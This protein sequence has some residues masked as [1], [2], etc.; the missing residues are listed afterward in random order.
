MAIYPVNHNVSE[1]LFLLRKMNN[2]YVL[3]CYYVSTLSTR[4]ESQIKIRVT[5][6]NKLVLKYGHSVFCYVRA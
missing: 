4:N 5:E 1:F 3:L 6:V 2:L